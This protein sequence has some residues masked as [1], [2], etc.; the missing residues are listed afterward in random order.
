M[1][2]IIS[3]AL[4]AAMLFAAVP[5]NAEGESEPLKY[6]NEIAAIEALSVTEAF[7]EN[8]PKEDAELTRAEFVAMISPILRSGISEN[9]YE[10][11][12]FSDVTEETE[13]YNYICAA[14][15]AGAVRGAGGRFMPLK[16]ITYAE[17]VKILTD[18]LGYGV[19]AQRNSGYPDGYIKVAADLKITK[20]VKLAKDSAVTFG[21]AADMLLNTLNTEMYGIAASAEDISFG[22]TSK[23]LLEE[24]KNVYKARGIV[25]ENAYTSLDSTDGSGNDGKVT[26]GD[27]TGYMYKSLLPEKYFG[28]YVE[29]YYEDEDDTILYMEPVKNKNEVIKITDDSLESFS[30]SDRKLVYEVGDGKRTDSEIIPADAVLIYNGKNKPTYTETELLPKNGDVTL[31]DNDGDG[32]TDVVVVNSYTTVFVGGVDKEGKLIADYYDSNNKLDLSEDTPQKRSI[33]I[34]DEESK[35]ISVS[36]IEVYNVI[37]AAV[38]SDG[39]Y[40]RCIVSDNAVEGKISAVLT[41]DG[42]NYVKFSDGAQYEVAASFDAYYKNVCSAG[43]SGT[44]YLD[45]SGKACGFLS[46]TR[47]SEYGFYIKAYTDDIGDMYVK[48]MNIYGEMVSLKA[49]EKLKLDGVTVESDAA[50]PTSSQV[51]RYT[52]NSYGEVRKIDT[53]EKTS[54]EGDGTL[55]SILG[56]NFTKAKFYNAYKSFRAKLWIDDRTIF[57]IAPSNPNGASASDY[58]IGNYKMLNDEEYEFKGYNT[59]LESVTPEVIHVNMS[60]DTTV[61]LSNVSKDGIISDMYD[62]LNE[63]DEAVKVVSIITYDEGEKTYEISAKDEVMSKANNL[64]IGDYVLYNLSSKGIITNIDYVVNSDTKAVNTS[65][66][67]QSIISG[68]FFSGTFELHPGYVLNKDNN[69]FGLTENYPT[70]KNMPDDIMFYKNIEAGNNKPTQIYLVDSKEKKAGARLRKADFSEVRD[71]IRYG[72]ADYVLTKFIH[73]ALRTVVIYR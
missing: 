20:N 46:A 52:L 21:E 10:N 45:I 7:G 70:S 42:K 23:T 13:F 73:T 12:P 51:V 30:F 39:T 61:K 63:D 32:K 47:F 50:L 35:M 31:I 56:N 67:I 37:T 19:V 28:Y 66:D 11:S 71:Y 43:L 55:H 2:K 34:T 69:L 16:K 44:L 54:N 72:S 57:I 29:F 68:S 3:L 24:K 62:A 65:S 22:K 41:Q 36:D 53:A 5:V 48:M 4:A 18:I 33:I 58:T 1:K 60:G 25:R 15:E 14:Y 6:Q 8:V 40:V 26:I 27:F 64:R 59:S 49:A 9:T 38:S 17:A